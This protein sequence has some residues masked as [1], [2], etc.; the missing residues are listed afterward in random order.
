MHPV[1][2]LNTG[3]A[4]N[5]LRCSCLFPVSVGR[6]CF[7]DTVGCCKLIT[8][9]IIATFCSYALLVQIMAV[10]CPPHIVGPNPR[11]A[12]G[13]GVG[14][15]GTITGGACAGAGGTGGGSVAINLSIVG[16]G[17]KG[18]TVGG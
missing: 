4:T 18:H 11:N 10:V 13:G 1:S 17:G 14:G 3:R 8:L 2:S 16:D 9:L 15:G 5:K 12:R 6:I 7:V